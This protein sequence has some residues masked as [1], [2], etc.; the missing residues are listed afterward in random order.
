MNSTVWKQ[1]DSRW[2]S[3][4]YP[5]GSTMSGCGCGCVAC[6]HVIMEQD[7]YKDY[8]PEP[9]RQYMVGQ[10]FAIKGQGTTW[11]GITKTLEHY[12]YKVTHVGI[13]DPMSK[14]W[15]ELN[16]G[17]RIGIFLFKSGK[18]PNGTVWTSGGHYVAFT[19]YYVKDGKHYFYTKDSGARNHDSKT[20]G[21][22]TYENSMKGLVYQMWIVERIVVAAPTPV[23]TTTVAASAAPKKSGLTIDGKGGKSTIKATQAYFGTTQDGVITGQ[24]KA[25]QKYYSSITSVKF[26]KGGSGCVKKL[27]K[28][29][30]ASADGV[31]GQGT[32]K[33][34]QKKLASLGYYTGKIDGYFGKA[35][36]IA[37]QKFLNDHKG[38]KAVMPASTATTTTKTATPATTSSTAGM[39]SGQIKILNQARA[40]SWPK[41]TAA[42]KFAYK[43]G[44]ATS[45]FKTALKKAYPKRSS[46][47]KAP[48]VG[49][50][51]D[52]AVG[53]VARTSGLAPKYPR[54][55][56]EQRN[57]KPSGFT[58]IAKKNV[59]PIT[60]IKPGDIVLYDKTSGG[61]KGHTFIYGDGGIYEAANGSKY[62]HFNSSTAKLKKKYKKVIILRAK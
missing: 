54:G 25:N 57:Y 22:Y 21:Y 20:Y 44:S 36:M 4:P 5:S 14:A 37:W 18:A 47:S 11:A 51:C 50:S 61:K 39:T 43:G 42:K 32:A 59:K 1:Y 16:K 62:F 55:R 48:R 45:A 10:G 27:Q 13:N 53:V 52:V 9:V 38:Q 34:W 46:W 31:L 15:T 29:V 56:S 12:G 58:R 6:T 40:L 49:A 23:I 35:S 7:K 26:G 41:G 60:Y 30:G 19:D 17:N 3:K 2:G 33:K 24:K 8:T 28:W